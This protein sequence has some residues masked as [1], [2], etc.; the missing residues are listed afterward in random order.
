[1]KK[2]FILMII[3]GI[4]I[5]LLSAD[6]IDFINEGVILLKQGKITESI[7]FFEKARGSQPSSPYPYYYLGEAYYAIGKKKEALDNYTRAIEIDNTNPDFYYSL[8]HLYIS[9]GNYEEAIKSLDEVIK[10]A[11]SSITGKSAKKLKEDIQASQENREM[12]QKWS[13]MEEE[14]KKQEEEKSAKTQTGPQGMFPPEFAGLTQEGAAKEEKIPVEQLI[15]R[16]KFGTEKIRHQSASILPGYEQADLIKVMADMI[17]I[18]KESK[19]IPVRK[20]VLLAL[21][22]TE[23]PEAID[24]VLNIIQDKNELFD[25]KITALDSIARLRRDDIAAVLRNTLKTLVD[26]RENERAEAQK[27]IKDITAKVESIE[28]QKIALNMQINQ[29]EQK[30]MELQQ[31]IGVSEMFGGMPGEPAGMLPP[32][33]MQGMQPAGQTP[34]TLQEIQK[35]PTEIRKIEDSLTKKRSDLANLDKQLIELQ[36][37]K[38]KYEALLWQREQKRTDISISS[39]STP[40]ATS[41]PVTTQYGPPGMEPGILPPGMPPGVMMPGGAPTF[42][43]YRYE[44]TSED[45]NEII[46][47]LKVIRALG[48]MRDRQGL[49]IIKKGWDEYGVENEKIYYFLT[50]ARLGDFNGIPALVERIGM[51]YPQT[52]LAGEIELRKG[53]IEVLGEYI[54]QKPDPKLQGLIEFLSEEGIYPEIKGAAASVLASLTKAPGK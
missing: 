46:F 43:V 8:A 2:I 53:I 20:N 7:R 22:K 35:I 14:R 12:V 31:K 32:G 47:A 34:L 48:N 3:A 6:Y 50:L 23:S 26:K 11:P 13:R 49:S 19:E 30:R 4:C 42:E 54:A 44:E 45:K 16:I 17:T 25:I 37:Q 15:K 10:I 28:S 9:E 33:V 36:Q 5:P 24:T 27:N 51:D 41:T 40:P 29:E 39:A 38:G 1:M 52:D 18:I 21:G